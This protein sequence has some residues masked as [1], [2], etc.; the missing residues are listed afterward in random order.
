MSEHVMFP[1]S[2]EFKLAVLKYCESKNITQAQ[3]FR[4]AVAPIIKYDLKADSKPARRASVS[5]EQKKAE[6]HEYNKK[7]NA[8]IKQLISDDKARKAAA[9]KKQKSA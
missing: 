3:L 1:V 7:H 9:A 4:E 2:E 8:Y 6:R 5:E